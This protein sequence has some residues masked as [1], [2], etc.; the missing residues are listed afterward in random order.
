MPQSAAIRV[1]LVPTTSMMT[2][3]QKWIQTEAQWY[4][5]N[6]MCV[7]GI[8]T[9]SGVSIHAACAHS[10]CASPPCDRMERLGQLASH[11]N[12]ITRTQRVAGVS[13]LPATTPCVK[14]HSLQL[15]QREQMWG[16][17]IVP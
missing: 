6:D 11:L 16:C 7:A 5:P 4:V 17:G 14:R 1:T 9:S 13:L 8:W 2:A 10:M 3:K 12:L 15:W